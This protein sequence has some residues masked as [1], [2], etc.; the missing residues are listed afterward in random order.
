MLDSNSGP[1]AEPMDDPNAAEPAAERALGGTGT[2]LLVVLALVLGLASVVQ[3]LDWRGQRAELL[4]LLGAAGVGEERPEILRRVE[5]ERSPVAARLVAARILVYRVLAMDADALQAALAADPSAL[6][7]ELARAGDLARRVLE[8]QPGN[9]QAEMILGASVYLRRTLDRDVRLVTE[10]SRWEKPLRAAVRDGG[11]SN[12]PKR[13]L[14]GAYLDVWPHLSAEKKALTRDLLEELFAEDPGAFRLLAPVWLAVE[15]DPDVA[16]SVIPERPDAWLFLRR[17]YA[18]SRSWT[19]FLLAH[20]RWLETLEAQLEARYED[21]RKRLSLGDLYQSRKLFLQNVAEA[22]P[23]RRF[24]G[25]VSRS[26]EA[27]PPGLHGIGRQDLR[28]WLDWS[29]ELAEVGVEGLSPA[30]QIRLV[31]ALGESLPAHVAAHAALVSGD[32]YL[33]ERFSKL[34][35]PYQAARAAPYLLARAAWLLEEGKTQEAWEALEQVPGEARE[36]VAWARIRRQAARAVGDPAAEATAEE[37]LAELRTSELPASRWRWRNERPTLEVLPERPADGVEIEIARAP[38]TGAVVAVSLD[39]RVVATRAVRPGD[40]L[41]LVPLP[42]DASV[43]LFE[44]R[45]LAGGQ[46]VPGAVAL[47]F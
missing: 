10:A 43:H 23:S 2:A 36:G 17:H 6:D 11:G 47:V 28:A 3:L 7:E 39:G 29:L 21:A 40:V 20:R 19:S 13:I 18:D 25:V 9:W 26:L 42:L 37:Q 30:A 31:D 1:T 15:R 32:V 8:V 16:F 38:D 46:V 34:V 45:L 12:E 5:R 33:A 22:P 27:F 24:A 44:V 14:V 35:D 41:R 4:D